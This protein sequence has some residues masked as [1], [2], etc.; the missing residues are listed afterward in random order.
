MNRYKSYI[1]DFISLNLGTIH[2]KPGKGTITLMSRNLLKANDLD[3]KL[4]TLKRI[5]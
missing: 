5:N 2:L 1:K 3:I 4:V